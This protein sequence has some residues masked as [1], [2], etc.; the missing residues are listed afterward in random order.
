MKYMTKLAFF[1][2]L[3]AFALGACDTGLAPVSPDFTEVNKSYHSVSGTNAITSLPLTGTFITTSNESPP[4]S[5]QY[6]IVVDGD[7]ADPFVVIDFN[8]TG[9]QVPYLDAFKGNP[10][11]A[12]LTTSLNEFLHFYNVGIKA[13]TDTYNAP[14]TPITYTVAKRENFKVWL[15]LSVTAA[16]KGYVQYKI[17]G[18]KLTYKD[19]NT[20]DFDGNG[21][22]GEPFY[23]DKYGTIVAVDKDDNW[24]PTA[25]QAGNGS[26]YIEPGH[27]PADMAYIEWPGFDPKVPWTAVSEST[28]YELSVTLNNVKDVVISDYTADIAS[29]I[30]LESYNGSEYVAVPL[31]WTRAAPYTTGKYTASIAAVPHKGIYRVRAKNGIVSKTPYKGGAQRVYYYNTYGSSYIIKPSSEGW[32]QLGNS[33][34]INDKVLNQKSSGKF[35]SSSIEVLSGADG[36]NVTLVYT[37]DDAKVGDLGLPAA[38]PSD[39]IKLGYLADN[40][41]VVLIPTEKIELDYSEIGNK[42]TI[43]YTPTGGD[44][45]FVRDQLKVT[46]A[47]TVNKSFI[48]GLNIN[49][50]TSNNK[51]LYL[52]ISD[53]YAFLGDYDQEAGSPVKPGKFGNAGNV[54]LDVEGQ[55]YFGIYGSDD[56]YRQWDSASPFVPWL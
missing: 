5:G 39:S 33:V 28:E 13:A 56:K 24:A 1:A 16:N 44:P 31:T 19:G 32:E 11:N 23:D 49:N 40:S 34:A 21:I 48:D 20:F 14:S 22:A 42:S 46:L 17:D 15:R 50:D 51:K 29:H 53:A 6:Y 36:Y 4:S 3:A 55:Y 2:L 8:G 25:T 35:W 38:I 26:T 10:D 9:A 45:V 43:G 54:S 12:T 52:F 7:D 47:P 37:L 30:R 27:Q 41:Q 18:S